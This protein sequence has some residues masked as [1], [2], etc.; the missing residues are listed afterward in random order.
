MLALL[1]ARIQKSEY[2]GLSA[3]AEE[4]RHDGVSLES[5]GV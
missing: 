5:S 4:G 3:R 2:K 1:L